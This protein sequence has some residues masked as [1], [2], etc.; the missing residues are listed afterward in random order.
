[1]RKL[2]NIYKVTTTISFLLL[3]CSLIQ[4]LNNQV[5]GYEFSIYSHESSFFFISSIIGIFNGIYLILLT[6]YE[7]KKELWII[8]LFEIL[9]CNLLILSF[10]ILKGYLLSNRGDVMIYIG[11]ARDISISGH[12]SDSNVYP[13]MSIFTSSISQLSKISVLTIAQYIS[14]L[15]FGLYELSI[16]CLSKSVFPN[17]SY[18]LFSVISSVPIFFAWFSNNMYYMVLATFMIPLLM[19]CTL[20][21]SSSRF[22]ILSIILYI[23]NPFF[24]PITSVLIVTYIFVYYVFERK[25]SDINKNNIISNNYLILVFVVI[26]FWFISE[27][28]LLNNFI[29]LIYQVLE[30]LDLYNQTNIYMPSSN[31]AMYYYNALGVFTSIRTFLLMNMDEIIYYTLFLFIFVKIIKNKCDYTKN[32]ILINFCL[33]A[34]TLLLLALFFTS[35]VHTPGR[36]LNLNPNMIL[37]PILIGYLAHNYYSNRKFVKT[38]LILFL[39]MCSI[40][41]PIFSLYPS[42]LTMRPNEQITIQ[43]LNGEN[44]LISKKDLNTTALGIMN[45]PYNFGVMMFGKNSMF[46]RKDLPSYYEI[47]QFY[48]KT[49][50]KPIIFNKSFYMVISKMDILTYTQLWKGISSY[51]DENFRVIREGRNYQI[52]N[53]GEMFIYKIS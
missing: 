48:N 13:L 17:K 6:I 50:E 35:R 26:I 36:L 43:E 16:Y 33:F 10:S 27:Y 51:S 46:D 3:T 53:N 7:N 25:I 23:I 18:V 29:S 38:A 39:I 52:Y 32:I 47:P 31:Q 44:W 1:M 21:S 37:T 24:H 15:F 40:I 30:S 42:P 2:T 12:F 9:F 20:K 41:T 5:Q 4:I 28:I 45:S 49:N 19:Y 22:K 8:G 14:C 11:L 34:G